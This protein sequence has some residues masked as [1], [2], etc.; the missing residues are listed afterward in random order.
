MI[1]DLYKSFKIS[2]YSLHVPFTQS[3]QMFISYQID[4]VYIN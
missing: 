2:V 3:P 4:F 1:L